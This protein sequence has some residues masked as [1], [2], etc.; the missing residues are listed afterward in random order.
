MSDREPALT[1][2]SVWSKNGWR[3]ITAEEAAEQHPGGT[4]SSHSGLFFCDLCGQYVTFTK[5]GKKTR[6]FMH[7]SYEKSKD[8]PD[9]TNVNYLA[10]PIEMLNTSAMDGNMVTSG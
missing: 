2:V 5:E 1:R 4:V 8:C 9:R 3:H 10:T 7:S 6:H